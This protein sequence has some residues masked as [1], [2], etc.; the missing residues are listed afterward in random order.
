MLID[1]IRGS[2]SALKETIQEEQR[3]SSRSDLRIGDIVYQCMDRND[4]LTLKGDY[5]TRYKYFVIV[6]KKSNGDSIGLCLINSDL[7]FYKNNPARQKFQYTMKKDNY[8][9]ILK[10]DSRLDCAEL[11]EMKARKSIAVKAE[12]VGHLTPQDE[13]IIIPLVA[14]CEFIQKRLRKVYGIGM[15]QIT[16]TENQ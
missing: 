2:L 15:E 8:P 16:E 6:G 9:G 5:N 14:G 11:F 12:I 7:D 13:K 10:K 4:G 1:D 3:V